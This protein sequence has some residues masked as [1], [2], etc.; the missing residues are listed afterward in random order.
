MGKKGGSIKSEDNEEPLSSTI[1]KIDTNIVK[2]SSTSQDN[3]TGSNLYSTFSDY[4]SNKNIVIAILVILLIISFLG[5][6]ILYFFGGI[7]QYFTGLIG[8][9]LSQVLSVFGY[10]TGTII[11]KT[12]DIVT[13][14]AKV[15]ID[16]AD[17]TA[18]SVG[19][20]LKNSNNQQIPLGQMDLEN[21]MPVIVETQSP[22]LDQVLNTAP[23]SFSP[24][25]PSF[26]NTNSSI[27]NTISSNKQPWC[28][29]GEFQGRRGCVEVQDETKCLSGQVFTSQQQ[30][31]SSNSNTMTASNPVLRPPY[32][33]GTMMNWGMP[34]P[35]MPQFRPQQMGPPPGQMMMGPPPGQ[36]MMGPP[37]GQMMMGPPPGQMMG[38]PPGQ[39]MGPPPGQMMG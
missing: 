29:I 7:L 18:H 15:G 24:T 17:G 33:N 10:T 36:M 20:L 37:P 28:L 14:T 25:N 35:P 30:C 11:N 31:M 6:N 13:D 26:D 27:Q 9:L 5:V 8:P 16:I 4:V 23:P 22:D 19:N 34:P 39:M 3:S 12:A 1:P 38:P 21:S 2:D 32:A